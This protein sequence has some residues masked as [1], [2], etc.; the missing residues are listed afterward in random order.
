MGPAMGPPLFS[1][2]LDRKAGLLLVPS[3]NSI[4]IVAYN[5]YGFIQTAK[6]W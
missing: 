1:E 3:L 5:I 6:A 2:G 4:Q